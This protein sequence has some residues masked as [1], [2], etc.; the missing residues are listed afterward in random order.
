MSAYARHNADVFS[1]GPIEGEEVEDTI[2]CTFSLSP[3]I[4]HF[5]S[6]FP[7]SLSPLGICPY[8]NRHD[9]PEKIFFHCPGMLC[10]CP[11]PLHGGEGL[12]PIERPVDGRRTN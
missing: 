11:S 5:P 8:I 2:F 1:K 4:F 12:C 7:F 9:M 6:P 3:F 10:R